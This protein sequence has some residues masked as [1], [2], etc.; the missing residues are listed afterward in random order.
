VHKGFSKF[1]FRVQY[2]GWYFLFLSPTTTISPG[3]T[4]MMFV[5]HRGSM[6]NKQGTKCLGANR[7]W[8]YNF[9]YVLNRRYFHKRFVYSFFERNSL[10]GTSVGNVSDLYLWGIYEVLRHR[11]RSASGRRTNYYVTTPDPPSLTRE[12]W[13]RT[14]GKR[15]SV[16]RENDEVWWIKEDKINNGLLT[17]Y[18]D[19]IFLNSLL[20]I[21]CLDF[22]YRRRVY[23]YGCGVEYQMWWIVH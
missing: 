23:E 5:P 6:F 10:D 19:V 1:T 2:T 9:Y 16:K 8:P 18:T 17:R 20:R 14:G 7:Q 3:L 21:N 22:E 12:E 11:D 13:N 4:C 15:S